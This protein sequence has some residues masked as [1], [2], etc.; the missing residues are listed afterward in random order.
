MGYLPSSDR[1]V[2]LHVETAIA[3]Q[4]GLATGEFRSGRYMRGNDWDGNWTRDE[5]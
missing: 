4:I 1:L 3:L 5:A 2:R